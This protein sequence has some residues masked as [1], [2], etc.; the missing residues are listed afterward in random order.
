MVDLHET[1]FGYSNTQNTLQP[2]SVSDSS[3]SNTMLPS[4]NKNLY[5]KLLL[6]VTHLTNTAGIGIATY[7]GSPSATGE[8]GVINQTLNRVGNLLLIA[9]L[10]IVAGWT[11]PTWRKIQRY[12]GVHPNVA[13]V[14]WLFFA[15]VVAL[16]IW[17]IRLIGNTTYA[18]AHSLS[19]LDP[20]MGS[21]QTKLLL[22]FGTYFFTSTALLVGGWYGVS[23]TTPGTP[24]EYRQ[25]EAEFAMARESSN[26]I[27][28]TGQER[29]LK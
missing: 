1:I 19:D 10:C 4:K 27:E 9:V 20:V 22:I 29:R 7:A 28:M 8:G 26:D 23:R 14:K 6:G 12:Q 18:F 24:G 3:F 21:Y 25:I 16:P 11:L 15:T 13:P 2:D 5:Q 17:M